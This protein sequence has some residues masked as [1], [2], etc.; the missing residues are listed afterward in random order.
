[1]ESKHEAPRL[2][3]T[4]D[5]TTLNVATSCSDFSV[6]VS[7]FRGTFTVGVVATRSRTACTD[8]DQEIENALVSALR[9]TTEFSGGLPGD[10][11][12]L[13]GP[14]SDL[15]LAQ[16]MPAFAGDIE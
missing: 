7:I 13:R 16:P 5:M 2:Q 8:R 3:F 6:P 4:G 11:L 14:N 1:M 10:R 15:V 9:G 12:H